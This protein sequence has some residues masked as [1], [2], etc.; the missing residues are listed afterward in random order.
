MTDA[1]HPDPVAL[2]FGENLR[3]HREAAELRQ[4]DV[5]FL[6]S[7][8]RTEIGYLERGRRKPRIDTLIRLATALSVSPTD[9]LEGIVWELPTTSDGRIRIVPRA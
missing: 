1:R 5:A 3:R 2:R 4:E 6:A 9:L 7:L 8:H